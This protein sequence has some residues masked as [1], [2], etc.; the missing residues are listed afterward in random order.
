[1]QPTYQQKNVT[2]FTKHSHVLDKNLTL[3]IVLGKATRKI[4]HLKFFLDAELFIKLHPIF[5]G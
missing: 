3:S 1:M 2:N 4:T 5:K